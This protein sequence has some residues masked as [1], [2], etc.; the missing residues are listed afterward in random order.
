MQD[1]KSRNNVKGTAVSNFKKYVSV[2]VDDDFFDKMLAE[3]QL[4]KTKSILQSSWYDVEKYIQMQ[5]STAKE[6][7]QSMRDFVIEFSRY[8]LEID[9]N[10]VYRFFMRVNGPQRVLSRLPNIDKAYVDYA[11]FDTASN[12]TSKYTAITRIPSHLSG[13]HLLTIE[14]GIQGVLNVCKAPMKKFAVINQK[15]YEKEGQEITETVFE[16]NY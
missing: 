2:K 16:V 15:D 11:E 3:T 9:M 12:E 8:L 1:L 4:S 6:L 7:N 13:W 14:G 10:G 5:E